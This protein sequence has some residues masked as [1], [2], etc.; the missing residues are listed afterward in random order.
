MNGDKQDIGKLQA[1]RAGLLILI[2][3][4][5]IAISTLL[6]KSYNLRQTQRVGESA[7]C[8]YLDAYISDPQGSYGVE[9]FGTS[10]ADTD[11]PEVITAFEPR[12]ITGYT[13]ALSRPG[14]L[15]VILLTGESKMFPRVAFEYIVRH[16]SIV[17]YRVSRLQ[18]FS[19]YDIEYSKHWDH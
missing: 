8:G 17:G 15:E 5:I 11:I 3:I 14:Y 16:K 10:K 6:Y 12:P 19:R 7:V 2:T 18:P 9:Y 4:S 13:I 1:I